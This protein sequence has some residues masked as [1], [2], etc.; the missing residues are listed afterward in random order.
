[1]EREWRTKWSRYIPRVKNLTGGMSAWKRD[2]DP[3]VTVV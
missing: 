3:S 1:M 2:V